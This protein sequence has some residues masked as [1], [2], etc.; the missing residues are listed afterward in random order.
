MADVVALDNLLDKEEPQYLESIASALACI[1]PALADLHFALGTET[2]VA[3]IYQ[4]LTDNERL[5]LKTIA[6]SAGE[7]GVDSMAI[8]H[9]VNRSESPSLA[10][11]RLSC[12]RLRAL[13]LIYESVVVSGRIKY[14]MA[15]ETC[16]A[17]MKLVSAEV[18]ARVNADQHQ[19][20]HRSGILSLFILDL[21]TIWLI[22]QVTMDSDP[23]RALKGSD[24]Y[25]KRFLVQEWFRHGAPYRPEF[26]DRTAFIAAF[27]EE[28]GLTHR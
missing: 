6:F 19:R 16:Q 20:N 23:E 4:S 12:E 8:W 2:G 26:P 15:Q 9:I 18:A 27:C 14:L 7:R 25:R 22:W 17:V 28:A 24:P 10:D 21:T 1:D 5:A 3:R 13:G 11:G